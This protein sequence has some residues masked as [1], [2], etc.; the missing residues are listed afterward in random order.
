MPCKV[1]E[2]LNQ[3]ILQV[4]CNSNIL[5]HSKCLIPSPFSKSSHKLVSCAWINHAWHQAFQFL[6]WA[7]AAV[8]NSTGIPGR[9]EC[10][11]RVGEHRRLLINAALTCPGGDSSLRQ[12]T[13]VSSSL[14]PHRGWVCLGLRVSCQVKSDSGKEGA[15]STSCTQGLA[16]LLA[17]ITQQTTSNPWLLALK[18]P[19][20]RASLTSTPALQLRLWALKEAVLPPPGPGLGRTTAIFT[21]GSRISNQEYWSIWSRKDPR[22]SPTPSPHYAG[23]KTELAGSPHTRMWH[24][25]SQVP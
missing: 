6:P 24:S 3:I 7:N 5:L 21:D 1:W 9:Q 22:D 11:F 2:P 19:Y 15:L 25:Q 20:W 10:T 18:S 8:S 12:E 16:V 23:E 14:G 13:P 4:P 17:V